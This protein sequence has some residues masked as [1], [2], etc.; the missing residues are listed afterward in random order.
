[1]KAAYVSPELAAQAYELA[2]SFCMCDIECNTA[3]VKSDGR[4][5]WNTGAVDEFDD[6]GIAKSIEYLDARG[7]VIRHPDNPHWV[8]FTVHEREGQR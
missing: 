8:R 1:M 6:G 2:D 5:W 3:P 4:R 7:L